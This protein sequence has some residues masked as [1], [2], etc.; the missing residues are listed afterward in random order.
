MDSDADSTDLPDSFDPR[1]LLK[2]AVHK[3]YVDVLVDEEGYFSY[4]LSDLGR[5]K[6][7]ESNDAL[8]RFHREHK[9][10]QDPPEC[11]D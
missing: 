9:P 8:L 10:K 2:A 7:A 4:R 1:E 5:K 3:G 6:I 11:Q